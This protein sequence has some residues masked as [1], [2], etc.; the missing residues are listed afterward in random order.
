MFDFFKEEFEWVEGLVRKFKRLRKVFMVVDEDEEENG[1]NVGILE[2]DSSDED[3]G[4][5]VV[6]EEVVVEKEDC[7]VDMELEDEKK[8][9]V[10]S[11][12]R[13]MGEIEGGV[14]KG[15]DGM[16][17]EKGGSSKKRKFGFVFGDFSSKSG[18]LVVKDEGNLLMFLC[19]VLCIVII[20]MFEFVN[21]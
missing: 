19:N 3:W 17:E 18:K 21:V 5:N 15:K 7:L 10:G 20:Y 12:K 14:S 11:L 16:E 1:G 9:V 4:K 2:D 8:E 6:I 13:K